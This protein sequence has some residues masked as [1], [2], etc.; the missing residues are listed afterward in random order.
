MAFITKSQQ[1]QR[2]GKFQISIST[3]GVDTLILRGGFK[4][5]VYP[6]PHLSC[7]ETFEGTKS[8]LKGVRGCQR[9]QRLV[10][11][12]MILTLGLRNLRF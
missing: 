4:F 2:T 8:G 3:I 5:Q 10:N 9:L 7:R 11:S 12:N 1:Y 6:P